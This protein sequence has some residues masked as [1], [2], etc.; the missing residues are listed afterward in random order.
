MKNKIT[1]SLLFAI[2][3]L[4]VFGQNDLSIRFTNYTN[5]ATTTNDTIKTKFVIKNLGSAMYHTGDTL[6]VSSRINNTYFGLELLGTAT[7]IVLTG[8]LHSGDSTIQDPGFLLGSQTLAFFP[9]ATT[10]EVCVAVWGKGIANV[11]APSTTF[12]N[13]ANPA[14]NI[15]CVTYSAPTTGIQHFDGIETNVYPNPAKDVLSFRFEDANIYSIAITNM[16][17]QTVK[18]VDTNNTSE[19]TITVSDLAEGVYAYSIFNTKSKRIAY[20]TFNKQ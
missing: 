13:D 7:P 17:G 16:L 15:T 20:G 2:T 8:M 12:T 5:G 1:L 4:N 11:N 6:Y 3:M 18:K 10:L 9:G 14:N 19:H